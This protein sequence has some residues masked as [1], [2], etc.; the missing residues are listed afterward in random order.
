MNRDLVN[1]A[2]QL[3]QMPKRIYDNTNLPAA[4]S[5]SGRL[6]T[7]RI[8]RPLFIRHSIQPDILADDAHLADMAAFVAG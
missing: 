4:L 8:V 6:V 2:R 3:M 1:D 7:K 5:T